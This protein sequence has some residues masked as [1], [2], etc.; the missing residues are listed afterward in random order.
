MRFWTLF[1][2][3]RRIPPSIPPAVLERGGRNGRKFLFRHSA[4]PLDGGGIAAAE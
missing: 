4:V 3:Y 1:R 2:Q